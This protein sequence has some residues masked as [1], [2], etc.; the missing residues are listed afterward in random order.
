VLLAP[1]V[2]QAQATSTQ[3]NPTYTFSTPGE[4]QVTLTVCKYG[5]QQCSTVVKTVTV[6]DPKPAVV[7]KSASP[8]AVEEGQ[9]VRL[10]GS[11]TGQPPLSYSWRVSLAGIPLI[12][13]PGA[14]VWWN[15]GSL[16]PGLYTL[17]FRAQNASGTATADLP[18]SLGANQ[19]SAFYTLTPC[20]VFD[21]RSSTPFLSGAAARTIAVTGGP[22]GI[23]SGA[24]AVVGNV[25]AVAPSGTG[26]ATL[27]PA[28]YPAQGTNINFN[29]GTTRSNHAV[30]QLAT[31]GSGTL[32]AA[33]A[34]ANGGSVHLLVDVTGYF[35]P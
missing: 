15:T 1:G 8:A 5:G 17:T 14:A 2:A 22:C 32:L 28:N 25:T 3:A 21:S 7:S 23:P 18:L 30:L 19:P 26:H 13:L 29:T 16:L 6:L 34:V 31:D 12:D 35:A 11:A 4:K 33:A 10:T 20:R 27:Y 24:R 9:M